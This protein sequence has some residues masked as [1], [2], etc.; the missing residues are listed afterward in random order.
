MLG[1]RSGFQALVKHQ[2]LG[3]HCMIH[4]Q[5]LAT[6]TLPVS[7]RDVLELIIGAV[8]FVKSSALNTRLFGKL[9]T[10][11][12][13]TH[14]TLLFYTEVRWLSR[15]KVLKWQSSSLKRVNS[16]FKNSSAMLN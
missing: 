11:M 8:N 16:S 2:Q 13:A 9:C 14:D 7:L 6:K 1:C 12:G 5:V 4:R 3:T 15:G 10:E